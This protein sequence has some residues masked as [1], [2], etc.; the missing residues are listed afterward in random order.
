MLLIFK[1]PDLGTSLVLISIWLTMLFVMGTD[2]KNILIFVAACWCAG[3]R[4]VSR[5]LACSRTI[6][7]TDS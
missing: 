7:R 1:Q 2:I 4:G 3:I 5:P 6:R